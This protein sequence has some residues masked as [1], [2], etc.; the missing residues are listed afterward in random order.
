MQEPGC[1]CHTCVSPIDNGCECVECLRW[2]DYWD[3]LTPAERESEQ[4]AMAQYANESDL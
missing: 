1:T 4:R 3:N 2:R